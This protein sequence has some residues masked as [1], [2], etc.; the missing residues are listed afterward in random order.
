MN[1]FDKVMESLHEG[2]MARRADWPDGVYIFKQIPA[3][4]SVPQT[5][6]VMQSLPETVKKLFLYRYN[7]NGLG[8]IIYENQIARISEK[9]FITGWAA[10]PDDIFA[11]NWEIIE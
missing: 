11:D 2:C 1:K 7:N 8:E 6:P 9:N 4:I 10:T 3:I 5:V